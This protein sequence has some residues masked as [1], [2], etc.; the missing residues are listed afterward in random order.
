MDWADDI[1]FAIL[2]LLDFF[3]AGKIPIDRRKKEGS[4]ERE[5]LIDGIFKRKPAWAEDRTSY[6]D[7]LGAILELFPFEPEHVI[8]TRRNTG[9]SCL[10]SR[11]D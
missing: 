10:L 3:C 5:R 6:I 8:A 11:P 7:A 2:D 1:T 9:P 4:A